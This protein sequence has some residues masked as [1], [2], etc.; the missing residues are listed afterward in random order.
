MKRAWNLRSDAPGFFTA[1]IGLKAK[2]VCCN[3]SQDQEIHLPNPQT[4]REFWCSGE[5]EAPL[6]TVERYLIAP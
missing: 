1:L 6:S 2:W 4:S 3:H 5:L